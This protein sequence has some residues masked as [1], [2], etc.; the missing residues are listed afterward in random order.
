[1]SDFPI[2]PLMDRVFVKKDDASV[3]KST[4]FHLPDSV[5]GRAPTGTVVAVGQ[6]YFDIQSGKFVPMSLKV[7]DRVWLKEF[8]GYIIRY[9]G[10]EVFVFNEREI[11]G[12]LRAND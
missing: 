7:G 11:I 8:D 6:G 4:G 12:K 9:E 3:D 2:E 5:K 10:H 1:M